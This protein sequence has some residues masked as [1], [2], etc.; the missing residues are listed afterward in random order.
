MDIDPVVRFDRMSADA[1]LDSAQSLAS[2]TLTQQKRKKDECFN[3][4]PC[5]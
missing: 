1:G 3:N 5:T 4:Y 2:E